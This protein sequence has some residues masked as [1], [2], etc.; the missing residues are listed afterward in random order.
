MAS[1]QWLNLRQT[2]GASLDCILGVGKTG[3]KNCPY[4]ADPNRYSNSCRKAPIRRGN[5]GILKRAGANLF[6]C[7]SD[8][9]RGK[10]TR[11]EAKLLTVW[12]GSSRWNAHASGF[13]RLPPSQ[14]FTSPCCE[15]STWAG[16][17]VGG[18]PKQPRPGATRLYPPTRIYLRHRDHFWQ[19]RRQHQLI[20][21]LH[22]Q[23]Q[24]AF[25]QRHRWH[26]D[27]DGR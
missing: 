8:S 24:R 26:S 27:D 18:V 9:H 15:R 10:E 12:F 13:W 11:L 20:S 3:E 5:P 6:P 19:R 2:H 7:P 22:E 1:E 21:Q 4:T 25:H 16:K 23:Y 14:R 17:P